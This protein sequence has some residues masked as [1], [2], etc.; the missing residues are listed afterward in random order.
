MH[1]IVQRKGQRGAVIVTVCLMLLFLLG[2]MGIALDLSRMFIVK[3]ELQTAMDSCALAAAQELDGENTAITRA[4]SAGM[5]AGNLNRVNLQSGT[6]DA[7]GQI[8]AGDITFRDQNFN[9]TTDPV[10]ANY[11]ECVH[12]QPAIRRWLLSALGA[13]S[14]DTTLYPATGNVWARAVAT[15]GSS[16]TNCPIP[17]A[18]RPK[19]PNA[20]APNFGYSPGEWV[21]LLMGPGQA[22]SGYIGWANLDGSNSAAETERELSDGA[23]GTEVGDSL[24]TPGVQA[25]VVDV[26]NA[27]FGLY[28]NVGNPAD[29]RPD[30]TGYSYTTTNWPSG[31]SAYNGPT[32]AGAHPTAANFVTKRDAYASCADSGTQMNG[33]NGCASIIGYSI[34]GGFNQIVPPGANVQGGH[35]QYGIN[36]RIALVPVTNTYPGSVEDYAC[37]LMLQPLSIPMQPSIQLEFLGRAGEPGSPC[38]TN[39]LPGGAAGPLVPMLVR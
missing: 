37:M 14:G 35:W 7:Q 3:T 30:R 16:Q 26:W 1:N 12:T 2:F 28:R 36:R 8:V 4:R 24:G 5:T 32:P 18:L 19:T 13:F 38:V 11:A 39:G 6:W 33:P 34:G 22:T 29:E 25:S 20:P 31:A 27:R 9:P 15:R 10:V 17:L 23:C 21:T